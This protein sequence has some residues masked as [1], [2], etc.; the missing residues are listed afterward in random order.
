MKEQK[1][2]ER[3]KNSDEN[4][5]YYIEMTNEFDFHFRKF[6]MNNLG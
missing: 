3:I 5:N 4:W 2:K 6:D 1:D